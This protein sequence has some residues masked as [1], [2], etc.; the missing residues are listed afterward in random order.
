M[1]RPDPKRPMLT[2]EDRKRLRRMASKAE[3]NG[4]HGVS[5]AFC[6]G[7]ADAFRWLDTGEMSDM[8][9]EVTR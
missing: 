4:E 1:T 6:K 5:R 7:V 8:L 9:R 2:L 3:V